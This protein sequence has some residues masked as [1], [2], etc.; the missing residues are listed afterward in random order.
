MHAEISAPFVG[1]GLHIASPDKSES[2]HEE[3]Q[4]FQAEWRRKRQTYRTARAAGPALQ[5]ADRQEEARPAGYIGA[6]SAAAKLSL[7]RREICDTVL[8]TYHT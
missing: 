7:R 3:C 6:V 2:L 4:S 1:L 8:L 5:A